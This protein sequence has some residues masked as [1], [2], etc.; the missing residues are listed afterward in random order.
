M[1]LGSPVTSTR[2]DKRELIHGWLGGF[3]E[4]VPFLERRVSSTDD[5]TGVR[6]GYNPI[7]SIPWWSGKWHI[8]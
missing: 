6:V 8:L 5:N 1:I 3:C 2:D 4:G 7:M